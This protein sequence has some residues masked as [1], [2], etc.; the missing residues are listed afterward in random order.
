MCTFGF[1]SRK[2]GG[3]LNKTVLRNSSKMQKKV[4]VVLLILTRIFF[5]PLI[6]ERVEKGGGEREKH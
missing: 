5:F 2:E 1:L 3:G 6:L 4:F